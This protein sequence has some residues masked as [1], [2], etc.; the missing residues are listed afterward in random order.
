MKLPFSLKSMERRKHTWQWPSCKQPKTLSFRASDDVIKTVNSV[1]FDPSD[2]VETPETW[3]TTS[4]EA[5]SQSTRSEGLQLDGEESCEAVLQELLLSERLFCDTDETR[6]IL[7][8][9]KEHLLPF[10]DSV[11]LA[12]E[13]EDPYGDFRRSMEEMIETH[14]LKKWDNLEEL[15]GWYLRV[16]GKDNH[17]FIIG[18]FADLLV[19]MVPSTNTTTD[20]ENRRSSFNPKNLLTVNSIVSTTTNICNC[21]SDSFASCISSPSSPLSPIQE[22]ESTSE[23]NNIA[24]S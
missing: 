23:E 1:Y 11:A 3:F 4:S 5:P 17:E 21:D 8:Q 10:E 18:A 14:G 2:E 15:L 16:N 20:H 22:N 13:S 9:E 12:M 19:G 24:I 7:K 6:S